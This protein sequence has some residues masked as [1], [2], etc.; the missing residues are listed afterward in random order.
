MVIGECKAIVTDRLRLN[1]EP[2]AKRRWQ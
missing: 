2:P 1:V